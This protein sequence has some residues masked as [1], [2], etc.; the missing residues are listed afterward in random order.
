[1]AAPVSKGM[2]GVGVLLV[3][4]L[5]WMHGATVGLAL[6]DDFL[7]RFVAITVFIGILVTYLS[8]RVAAAVSRCRRRRR[9]NHRRLA[10]HPAAR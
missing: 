8:Q 9:P 7:N 2:T 4:G 10:P 3:C 1:M 5:S 6:G